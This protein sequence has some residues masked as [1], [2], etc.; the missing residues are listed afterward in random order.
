M[1][2]PFRTAA[3][4]GAGI[5]GAQIAAHLAN[6]GLDVLLLDRPSEGKNKNARGEQLFKTALK[7]K[8]TPFFTEK[9]PRRIT[10]G[11][12]DE[13]LHKLAEVDWIIESVIEDLQIK[14][15]LIEQVEKVAR[16][17]AIISTNT[18]GLSLKKI[19]A[20]RSDSFRRRFLGTHFFN[21]PRY[22]KLLELIPTKDTDPQVLERIKWFGRVHLGK[23][24]II[25]K[26][27]PNFVGNRIGNYDLMPG[28]LHGLTKQDYTIE[29]VD[30][31]TGPLVG[32]P[33]SA[34]FRTADLVG[35]DTVTRILDNV[36]EAIPED[37]S[38]EIFRTPP[39]L[40][41]L[42]EK[43]ALGV[44]SSGGFY[45]K[46]GN[47]ICVINPTTLEYEPP[48]PLNL[49]EEVEKIAKI[50]DVKERLRALYQ[51]Q[52]RAGSFFRQTIIEMLAYSAR[53][54]P[55]IAENP[56]DI[57]RCLR[58]GWNWELG[59][60]EI[61]DTLGVESVVTDMKTAG[62]K[63]PAWV[64]EMQLSGVSSFYKQHE[65]ITIPGLGLGYIP[66]ETPKIYVFGQ[67]YLPL[68]TPADEIS[69]AQIKTSPQRTL[70]SNTEAALLNLGDG[71]VLYEFR[72]HGNALTIKVITGL[73]EVIDLIEKQDQI[74]G[75]IIGNEGKN[76][77][78]GLNLRDDLVELDKKFQELIQYMY[79]A[80]KPIVAALHGQV[81][82]GGWELAKTCSQVVAAAE[83]NIGLVELSVGLIP[84]GGGLTNMIAVADE[85]AGSELPQDIWPFLDRIFQAITS[86][87]ITNS[88][89]EAQ[90]IGFLSHDARIIIDAERR[91]YI[92]KQEVIRLYNEGFAP[93]PI[94]SSIMV[95]GNSAKARLEQNAYN[96]WQGGYMSAYDYHLIERLAYVLT[97][98]DISEP[99]LVHENYLLKLERETFISLL[100]EVKTQ[101]RISYMLTHKSP[102]RN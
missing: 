26:D 16:E 86:A 53:R 20:G 56:A 14:Q 34:T 43:G 25:A 54:I 28:I 38:R 18:S 102:L 87:K 92:A 31:L 7:L 74:L 1:Y 27:T 6:V 2:K 68:E 30:F 23:G 95:L 24:I 90:N 57:D 96:W 76:F 70:W 73:L 48:K 50:V 51:E 85:R 88:A 55:E 19:I 89:Y 40:R 42:V 52:G 22:M 10:L 46:Q 4:L 84:A 64:E 36:Y 47:K 11:N 66:L 35:L 32:R 37:E 79:Y 101:E 58:W 41:K 62:I 71:V 83:S 17:D 81:L 65:T 39:V 63:I 93:P 77:C 78:V 59:L 75:L 82:G 91:F 29:E 15:E 33:K 45:Q 44:K 80:N 21:P 72:S 5:M 67:G 60:F 100:A 99:T 3:V 12:F 69:L 13:D 49:G 8:P 94:R 9:I 97:G 98:G 61:W